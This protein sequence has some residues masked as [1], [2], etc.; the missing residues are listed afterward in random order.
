MELVGVGCYRWVERGAAHLGCA[1]GGGAAGG[2][3]A[4]GGA[5]GGCAVGGGDTTGQKRA[6]KRGARACGQAGAVR[7][8]LFLWRASRPF[9]SEFFSEF[10][11]FG[12][13]D[14]RVAT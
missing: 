11:P 8:G 14:L 13:R 2:G 12:Q 3:A 10:G 4:G 6:H 7:D 9:F 1:A 5:A